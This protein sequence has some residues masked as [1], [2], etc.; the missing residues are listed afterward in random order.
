MG[1]TSLSVF[2]STSLFFK[3]NNQF[4]PDILFDVHVSTILKDMYTISPFD[5]FVLFFNCNLQHISKTRLL[6]VYTLLLYINSL[7][8]LIV[9]EI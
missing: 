5:R 3:I 2:H 4:Q 8:C 1:V 9:G 6:T 7:N